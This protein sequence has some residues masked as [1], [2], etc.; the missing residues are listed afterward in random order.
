M[1]RTQHFTAKTQIVH[2]SMALYGLPKSQNIFMCFRLSTAVI[3]NDAFTFNFLH[4]QFQ[5]RQTDGIC[6]IFPRKQVLTFHANCLLRRQFA[7]NIKACFLGKIRKNNQVVIHWIF[8]PACKALWIN[9]HCASMKKI[10]LCCII[11]ERKK[12]TLEGKRTLQKKLTW[13]SD[14]TLLLI[15]INGSEYT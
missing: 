12:I 1:S 13:A 4:G 11:S 6:F 14:H 9:S 8:Y 5:R 7:Q 2:I 10:P 15:V 3:I